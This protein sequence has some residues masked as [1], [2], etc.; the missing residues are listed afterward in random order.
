MRERTLY[1]ANIPNRVAIQIGRV[2]DP[3]C[4]KSEEGKGEEGEEERKKGGK[5]R[6]EEGEASMDV[7]FSSLLAWG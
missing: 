5:G 4:Q 7:S 2:L 6:G 1:S 3:E